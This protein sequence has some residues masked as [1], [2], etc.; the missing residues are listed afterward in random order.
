MSVSMGACLF[1]CSS[2]NFRNDVAR[3]LFLV[4]RSMSSLSIR[5]IGFRSKSNE[6]K[7]IFYLTITFIC[8]HSIK[9][10][11][12]GQG[13]LKVKVKVTEYQGQMNRN[14]F[15]VNYLCFCDLC[16]RW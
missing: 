2:Y 8:L 4:C 9:T 5:F 7:V 14:R 16:V 12:K 11:F 6:R 3:N 1:V 13:H 10:C 15:C